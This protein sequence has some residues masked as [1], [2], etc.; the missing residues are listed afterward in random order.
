[1][2]NTLTS[3]T[4]DL[5][6]ALDQVSRE[7][8]GLIPAVSRDSSIERAAL[9]Q[10]VRSFVA[11]AASASNIT[12]GQLPADNGDQTFTNK[13]ISI[14][15]SRY[16]PIRWN[17]EEQR[18]MNTG[19][20]Y[21]SMLQAQFAQAM[22]TLVNE[23]ELDLANEYK[24]ASRAASPA[25]TTLFDAANYKDVANVRRILV[26]NGAPLNDL[27]LIL[28]TSSG[29]ALRGN[30]QYAGANTAGRDDILRQGVLLDVHGMAIRE[31]AAIVTHTNGTAASTP[32]TNAAGYAVGATVITL[33]ASS[34][35]GTG[36]FVA[37]DVIS[38]AGDPN[39]YVVV[40]GDDDI[41]DGGSITIAAPGLKVAIAAAE[42]AIT[43]VSSLE[44]NL[45]FSR[46]AIH[47]VTRVPARPLEGD[48]AA[49][50]MV[51]Q[52]AVSGLAFEVAMY[53]EYRQ[54]KFE[55]SLAWG[56]EVIKPEHLA[57][58]ID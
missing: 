31:S 29:A 5:Y 46:N 17:G 57:L 34:P 23:V 30:A 38:F 51:I 53:K 1:M 27:H 21:S 4:P 28:S 8:V 48:A 11:P 39:Q 18:A 41:S 32:D 26:E 42:T 40:S 14:S 12:A 10:T 9:N 19:P 2:A 36:T 58:L 3:L 47:L 44:R 22:R 43:L 37:G 49:D 55:I 15:K 35:S 6:A 25:G 7:L 13:T 20:G 16:V 24:K 45:A 56:Y 52:D 54:I 33:D 50:V